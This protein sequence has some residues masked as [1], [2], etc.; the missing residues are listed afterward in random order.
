MF[1]FFQTFCWQHILHFLGNILGLLTFFSA[2]LSFAPEQF[3]VSKIGKNGKSA[4]LI[5]CLS[6]A[7]ELS[8]DPKNVPKWSLTNGDLKNIWHFD[9]LKKSWLCF[10]RNRQQVPLKC[11]LCKKLFTRNDHLKQHM[12]RHT[13]KKPLKCDLCENWF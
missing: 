5:F 6:S 4:I 1:T 7:T 3:L 10:S 2:L 12:K 13:G 9:Q 8:R 11:E